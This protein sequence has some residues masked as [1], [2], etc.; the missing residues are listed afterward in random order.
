[1]YA[2]ICIRLFQFSQTSKFAL[3]P[4]L[5]STVYSFHP[6]IA[7][8]RDA[9]YER[10]IAAAQEELSLWQEK[11][12]GA[13]EAMAHAR[14]EHL[15]ALEALQGPVVRPFIHPSVYLSVWLSA[16]LSTRPSICLHVCPP[17][18]LSGFAPVRLSVCM[19]VRLPN[20]SLVDYYLPLSP[21]FS[22]YDHPSDLSI[23]EPLF[24][25]L[26]SYIHTYIHTCTHAYISI[27]RSIDLSIYYINPSI[28]LSIYLSIDRDAHYSRRGPPQRSGWSPCVAPDEPR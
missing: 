6:S 23:C 13:M 17:V 26:S 27:Y 5:T 14:R 9:A 21:H 1:M 7:S 11:D 8:A 20:Y 4:N 16:C 3:D 22:L 25:F 2:C 19:S 28:Y 18:C 10:E 15:E 12:R 24:R